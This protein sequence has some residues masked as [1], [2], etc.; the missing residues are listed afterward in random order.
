MRKESKGVKN[1]NIKKINGFPLMKYT[2]DQALE[3]KLFD[4]IVV[5]SDSKKFI[6]LSKKFGINDHIL[7]P[8]KLSSNTASKV[9]VY[10][11]AL[12][13]VE[14]KFKT[15]FN[16]IFDLDVTSP[17]RKTSDIKKAFS[18]FLKK[19]PSQLITGNLSKKNPYF[20]QVES[21]NG[22]VKLVKKNKNP[23]IRRQD[24]PKIYDMNASIYIFKRSTL[25]RKNITFPKK[26]II[27]QMPEKRSIDIDSHL[28]FKIVEMIMK[29]K[30]N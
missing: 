16:Y 5:S 15:K 14:K 30:I 25:M 11:H 12:K 6:N 20:N 29:C 19:N 8:K 10:K 26:T 3:T 28:D 9:K 1:K 18:L 7:R 4:K 13:I 22:Y 21:R 2:I 24:A 17:L 23:V 27:Y